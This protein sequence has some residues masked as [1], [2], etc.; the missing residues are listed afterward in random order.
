MRRAPH[1]GW[2]RMQVDVWSD[3]ACPWCALGLVRLKI[4][5]ADFEHADEVTV[6]HRAF[7][8]DRSAPAQ[9]EGTQEE[10]WLA[11]TACV[12]IRSVPGMRT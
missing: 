4:A 9:V 1:L 8:L 10:R 2:R 6:V 12:P 3:Y 7:E 5:L 11:S